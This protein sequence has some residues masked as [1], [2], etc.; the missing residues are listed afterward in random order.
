LENGKIFKTTKVEMT[1]NTVQIR[2]IMILKNRT[3]TPL[4]SSVV[5]MLKKWKTVKYL[6][7]QNVKRQKTAQIMQIMM[8]K[9][10]TSFWFYIIWYL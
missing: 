8:L 2:Q 1:E 6:K 3:I 4:F 9:N 10:R 7:Q 5:L